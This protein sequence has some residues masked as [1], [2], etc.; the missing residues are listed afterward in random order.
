VDEERYRKIIDLGIEE[1]SID[2]KRA[3]S[4]KD[5]EC[6]RLELIK[7][8]AAMATHG[9]GILIIGR[10][11]NDKRTG[12][13][14]VEQL[15]SFEVT[16]VNESLRKWIR[17]MGP[18]RVMPLQVGTD[19]LVV[20]D[21][22]AFRET[23]PCFQEASNC[24]NPQHR[25]RHRHFSKGD[26]YI[27]TSAAQTTKLSDP[28]D[29]H[30]VWLQMLRNVRESTTFS[31]AEVPDSNPYDEE[32][33]SDVRAERAIIALPYTTGTISVK[34]RPVKYAV[35]RVPR[36]KLRELL[37]QS[38]VG[39]STPQG[40]KQYMPYEHGG[41]TYQFAKG[42]SIENHNPQGGFVE[43]AILHNS[44]NFRLRRVFFE[45][46]KSGSIQHS[47]R[48]LPLVGHA[49][50]VTLAWSVAAKVAGLLCQDPDELF[51]VTVRVSG[52]QVRDLEDDS[53]RYGARVPLSLLIGSGHQGSESEVTFSRR[54]SA[55]ALIE[56]QRDLAVETYQEVLWIFGIEVPAATVSGIQN[57][58]KAAPGILSLPA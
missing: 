33:E 30:S 5:S 57:S 58:L 15:A 39:F 13:L 43:A 21:V 37:S 51:D 18:V 40:T 1:P 56:T 7:H 41:K 49:I 50:D 35:D 38:V 2:F 16:R 42:L 29:W 12:S 45:D 23:P 54:I 22:P 32:D 53:L 26:V 44:G 9:G 48:R 6:E 55:A 46:L 17:P 27:R 3:M 8:I 28:E 19:R 47:E 31:S 24:K 11:D 34:V 20:L 25:D 36:M 4:W 10:E 52:L 14:S